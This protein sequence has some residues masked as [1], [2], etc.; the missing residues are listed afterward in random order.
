MLLLKTLY[1]SWE[2]GGFHQLFEIFEVPDHKT[3]VVF[4][5]LEH[6]HHRKE[7]LKNGL[8]F[9]HGLDVHTFFGISSFVENSSINILNFGVHIFNG[10][11]NG[12]VESILFILV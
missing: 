10:Y 1:I 2:R 12:F 9:S 7:D 8:R 3:G 5:F 11:Q 4:L 6:N